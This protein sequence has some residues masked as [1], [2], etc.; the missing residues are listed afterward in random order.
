MF[1]VYSFFNSRQVGNHLEPSQNVG[2]GCHGQQVALEVAKIDWIKAQDGRVQ[3]NVGLGET[4][5]RNNV[6]VLFQN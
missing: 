5:T 2:T 4:I 1:H 3:T 6:L